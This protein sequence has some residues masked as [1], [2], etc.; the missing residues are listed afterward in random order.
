[1]PDGAGRFLNEGMTQAATEA[2]SGESGIDA[3]PSYGKERA[4]VERYVVP[5]TGLSAQE[6]FRGYAQA[7]HKAEYLA[8][9][10]WKRHGDKFSDTEDWGTG[11]REKLQAS[12]EDTLNT[13]I[14]LLYLVDEL[15]VGSES[16]PLTVRP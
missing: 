7:P 2:I 14:Y 3:Y 5:A 6:V 4:F 16:Q 8:D 13:N 10:I 15:G 1:M 9:I 12:I 11:V